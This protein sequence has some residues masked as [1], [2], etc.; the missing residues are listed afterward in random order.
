MPTTYAVPNGRTV[1]TPSLF[2]SNGSTQVVDNTTSGTSG[3]K[4]DLLWIKT[5]NVVSP[6]YSLDSISGVDYVL[7]TN[8]TNAQSNLATF[9]NS[10]NTNG[11]TM[12]TGNYAST[13]TV[14]GWQWKAG[15]GTT[16]TNTSGT[17]TST[18]SVNQAAGFSV[19]SYTGNG[20][21][22]ATIGHGLGA[23]PS[24]VITKSRSSSQIWI[25]YHQAV[26]K[27]NYLE[28]DSTAAQASASNWID[29]SP[30]LITQNTTGASVNA[31]GTTYIAYCWAQVPGFSSFGS[32]TG[33]GSANGPFIYTG[34]KPAYVMIK[35]YSSAGESW[36]IWDSSRS[37][38]N[39]MTNILVANVSNA[40][41][42]NAFPV[43]SLSNGFQIPTTWT[44]INGSGTGYIYIAFAENPSKYAN[45]S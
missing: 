3:F 4:P 40:E 39:S 19:V 17:I 36:Y 31:N 9:V 5:R 22:G 15:G 34:F 11:F 10:F 24:M 35:Q 14:V 26:G 37:P 16:N 2:T 18:T 33:N 42:T 6:C 7:T 13:N 29:T 45:A 30:T 43:N 12:G 25:V 23:T 8:S 21:A 32:Y 44:G 1:F 28:L 41:T 38:Y 27:S 20:V